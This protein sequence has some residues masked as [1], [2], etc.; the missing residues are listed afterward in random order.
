MRSER[1]P[2][3]LTQNSKQLVS[4]TKLAEHNDLPI[5]SFT[6]HR[7]SKNINKNQQSRTSMKNPKSTNVLSSTF[8]PFDTCSTS[9]CPQIE[10]EQK[11]LNTKSDRSTRKSLAKNSLQEQ[12][13]NQKEEIR[14]P[15]TASMYYCE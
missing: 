15:L 14:N 13:K 8:V 5:S 12:T 4:K 1:E 2:S 9:E 10:T 6:S 3:R 11:M 7:S